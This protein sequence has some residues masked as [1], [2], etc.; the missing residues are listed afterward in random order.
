MGNQREILE[1]KTQNSLFFS[2]NNFIENYS[3]FICSAD[4]FQMN[5]QERDVDPFYFLLF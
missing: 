2:V 5:A 3:D 4:G 1:I